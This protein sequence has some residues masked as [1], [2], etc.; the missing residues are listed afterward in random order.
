MAIKQQAEEIEITTENR[1]EVI[2][3]YRPMIK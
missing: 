2:K 1:E 3:R